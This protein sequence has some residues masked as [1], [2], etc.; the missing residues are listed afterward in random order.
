MLSSK[1]GSVTVF[2]S[3][4]FIALMIFVIA[5]IGAARDKLVDGEASSLND[6]WSDSILGEFDRNL[7]KRYDLLAFQGFNKEIEK[8][9]DYYG[10]CTF[11][12]KSYA[13]F[14]GYKVG[15]NAYSLG[16]IENFNASVKH[17]CTDLKLTKLLNSSE[18]TSDDVVQRSINNQK[19]IKALP[20]NGEG[21]VTNGAITSLFEKN[22]TDVLGNM[23][24]K[25]YLLIYATRYFNNYTNGK[26]NKGSYFRNELEY[27]LSGKMSDK[28]NLDAFKDKFLLVR[29]A[30]NSAYLWSDKEKMAAVDVIAATLSAATAE[31]SFTAIRAGLVELWASLEAENDWKRIKKGKKVPIRKSDDTWALDSSVLEDGEADGVADS[32]VNKGLNYTEYLQLMISAINT[33]TLSLRMMDLIQID[34]RYKYYSAFVIGEYNVGIDCSMRVNGKDYEIEKAYYK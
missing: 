23:G 16:K 1:K 25:S 11:S 34:M 9:L 30:M 31:T 2:L 32:E 4:M 22:K 29:I 33:D 18:K 19:I 6:I 13:D 7:Y 8:E 10:S 15:L 27:I 20:S 12:S 14:D 24:N 26:V 17:A 3:L 28:K 21:N 5:V